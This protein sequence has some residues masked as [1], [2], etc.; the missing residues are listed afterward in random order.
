MT[1]I[2]GKSKGQGKKINKLGF[3]MA[4]RPRCLQSP[5]SRVQWRCST[6]G[7]AGGCTCY[8][9]RKTDIVTSYFETRQKT[10]IVMW[11]IPRIKG[12]VF[13]AI[14]YIAWNFTKICLATSV[15]SRH[16]YFGIGP[17]A[18]N[19]VQLDFIRILADISKAIAYLSSGGVCTA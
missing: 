11:F 14:N 6:A 9:P 19:F 12:S 13:V 8:A 1:L 18:A 3:V 15:C 5:P 2:Y 10:D 4:L 7:I 16:L 17:S